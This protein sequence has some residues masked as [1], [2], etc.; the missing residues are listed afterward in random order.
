MDFALSAEQEILKKEA[1]L[2]LERECPK[3]V[4]RELEAGDLGYSPEMWSKMAEL[5]WIGLA[6]PEEYGGVGGDLIDLAVLFEEIGRAACPCPMFSTVVLGALPVLEGGGAQQKTELVS[7]VARGERILALALTEPEADYDL[8]HMA[9]RALRRR[10]GFQISGTKLFVQNAHVADN[11]LLVAGMGRRDRE[12]G[13]LGVFVV[14][15]GARGME[16]TPLK[17]IGGDRQF[18]LKLDRVFA[19]ADA[20][21]GGPG[22]GRPLVES[23]LQRATAIQCVET[24][25]VMGRALEM[26]AGYTSGRFQFNRPIASFQAVQHRLADMLTDVEGARWMS[27]QAVWRVAT[28]L[29]A[30]REVAVAKA[31]TG[32]ACQR[33][34]YGAQHLHG[35]VGMDLDYDLHFYFRRAKALELNLGAAPLH[36]AAIGESLIAGEMELGVPSGRRL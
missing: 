1:R 15:A 13:S 4:V 18:E 31:W 28:G 22:G 23:T 36:R 26:T 16:L 5:G 7:R 19:P 2:F 11:L 35:G 14:E 8:R 9:T 29:P 10:T 3:K 6:I 12:G 25:G 17:T 20:M 30:A 32:D 33:V 27:Y 21:L 24:L 34:A